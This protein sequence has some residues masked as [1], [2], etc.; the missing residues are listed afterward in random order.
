M[1]SCPRRSP[2]VLFYYYR[3][4]PG[5]GDTYRRL[6]NRTPTKFHR[7]FRGA[8]ALSGR[9]SKQRNRSFEAMFVAI[10]IEWFRDRID[11]TILLSPRSIPRTVA[12]ATAT[13]RKIVIVRCQFLAVLG[14]GSWSCFGRLHGLGRECR[15]LAGFCF[16]VVCEL[17]RSV[18][19]CKLEP[20]IHPVPRTSF[21][22]HS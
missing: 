11:A 1:I 12:R 17:V 6:L 20:M 15:C 14:L 22:N 7:V 18:Y 19:C 2:F 13:R 3:S 5:C 16:G 10:L 4:R 8:R 9:G 21:V